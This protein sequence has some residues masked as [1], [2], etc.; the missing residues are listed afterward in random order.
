MRATLFRSL[1]KTII[2]ACEWNGKGELEYSQPIEVTAKEAGVSH[3]SVRRVL[4]A[5][6]KQ[7]KLVKAESSKG[8]RGKASRYVFLDL[9]FARAFYELPPKKENP[10]HDYPYR[11]SASLREYNPKGSVP[12]GHVKISSLTPRHHRLI[13]YHFRELLKANGANGAVR[14]KAMAAIM[15]ELQSRTMKDARRLYAALERLLAKLKTFN[16]FIRRLYRLIRGKLFP[17]RRRRRKRCRKP[18]PSEPVDPI[19][20]IWAQVAEEKRRVMEKRG[21]G[22]GHWRYVPD[23]LWKYQ[24]GLWSSTAKVHER[25]ARVADSSPTRPQLECLKRTIE[26]Y[27]HEPNCL[28]DACQRNRDE[29]EARKRK[30][31]RMITSKE[32]I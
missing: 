22:P 4:V 27:S 3:A 14:Q 17:R 11:P 30:M 29:I 6:M 25:Q 13:A 20:R 19:E 26:Q 9:S 10:T 23:D 16:G 28:C 2:A 1:A 15:P 24:D 31:L 32:V 18:K 21:D 8:G 12:E 7:R 5:M